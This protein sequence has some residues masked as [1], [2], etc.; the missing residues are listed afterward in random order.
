M[1]QLQQ[2]LFIHWQACNDI[3][4]KLIDEQHRGIVSIINTFYYL[5]GHGMDNRI[6][7]SCINDTM[8]N[9]SRV[10]FIT[11]EG[12]L[13]AVGYEKI[14]E[15]KALHRKLLREIERIEYEALTSND[16]KPLL[17]FLKKW[18]LE[19]INE[20]DMKYAKSLSEMG[21]V[22]DFPHFQRHP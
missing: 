1:Q 15:H 12:F 5:M 10:H 13:E 11:E 2:R 4:I 21:S 8:C 16:A 18:W 20:E 14:E 9:Y 22:Q 6:L 17:N 3:G 7:Y 19:H